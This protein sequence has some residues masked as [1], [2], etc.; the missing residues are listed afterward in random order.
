MKLR[1]PRRRRLWHQ[2]RAPAARELSPRGARVGGG[3]KQAP[4]HAL[5]QVST[6]G[7]ALKPYPSLIDI[8]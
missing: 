1:Y 4:H 8:A 2:R 3:A 6:D 7:V 5:I